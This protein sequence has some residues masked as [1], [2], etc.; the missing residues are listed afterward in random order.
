MKRIYRIIAVLLSA[1][2]ILT[3]CGCREAEDAGTGL[4]M[5]ELNEMSSRCIRETES[6]RTAVVQ[7]LPEELAA[8]IPDVPE[9]VLSADSI[10]SQEN[11]YLVLENWKNECKLSIAKAA[12]IAVLAEE[13]KAYTAIYGEEYAA[14]I[15][16]G[17]SGAAAQIISAQDLVQVHNGLMTASD[18]VYGSM[19]VECSAENIDK[20]AIF[21]DFC[22][23][24]G[25]VWMLVYTNFLLPGFED[26][27]QG[28]LLRL[29]LDGGNT[30]L[31]VA[32]SMISHDNIVYNSGCCVRF[33]L[34]EILENVSAQEFLEGRNR[35]TFTL[36]ARDNS[37]S[38]SQEYY[39]IR[40]S[41]CGSM[42][43][44]A[45]RTALAGVIADDVIASAGG[46]R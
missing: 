15:S 23:L 27:E 32:D 31:T 6:F 3:V 2:I 7:A 26:R 29:V 4:D 9:L 37:F 14:D 44:A 21:T 43:A 8:G 24:D 39:K 20:L 34:S 22:T 40:M 33:D 42:D 35:V 36:F 18:A 13:E 46:V 17:F 5:S 28:Y 30:E 45:Y 19:A 11:V 38:W 10:S 12:A 1:M 41:Q 25:D 16:Q